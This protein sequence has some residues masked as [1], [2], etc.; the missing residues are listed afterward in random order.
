V[1]RETARSLWT[2]LVLMALVVAV[3]E[4]VALG[5][6]TLERTVITMLI[7]L[8][9]VVGLYMFVGISGV[10]S[11]GHIAF[12]A[13]GAYTTAILSIP[14]ETK[15]VLLSSMPSALR[16]AH[17]PP[18]AAVF[19]GGAAAAVFALVVSL[20]LARL[21]GLVAA[22]GTFALLLIVNVVA[23]AWTA[24]TNGTTGMSAIPTNTSLER[25]LLFAVGAIAVGFVY[26]VSRPGR[27]LRAS[28]EDEA[29]ARAVGVSVGAE[30]AA[31]F[32]ASAFVVG[33]AGGL[34]AQYLGSIDPSAFFLQITFLTIAM[35]VVGGMTSLSG[36]VIGTI[37]I[38][39]MAELLRRL[40]E[41]F[42]VGGAE[43][44]AP[45]G[46][47][48]VGLGLM[49]LAILVLR[50]RGLTNGR[51]LSWPGRRRAAAPDPVP[52]HDLEVT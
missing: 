5:G 28:R 17:V 35:L 20:P 24:V 38:A 9:V 46:L 49:M 16:A 48:N 7:N 52:T 6:A 34:Y 12:M 29:A 50:P 27:R 43:I 2:P 1:T 36:A 25:T 30:R 45:S 40:E 41:G 23:G 14:V 37:V 44:D 26:Q 31:S 18:L 47:Q 19:L 21:S 8:I 22:L 15:D 42:H 11:F 33:V 10:F 4:L 51:E 39:T 3:A 13:V 32:V